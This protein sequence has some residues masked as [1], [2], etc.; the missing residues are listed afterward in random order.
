MEDFSTILGAILAVLSF[1]AIILPR[2]ITLLFRLHASFKIKSTDE[3]NANIVDSVDVLKFEA[4]WPDWE[5]SSLDGCGSS[6][7]RPKK[8]VIREEDTA[9]L[10]VPG[11][12]RVFSHMPLQSSLGKL[13]DPTSSD[14]SAAFDVCGVEFP[15]YGTFSCEQRTLLPYLRNEWDMVAVLATVDAAATRLRQVG[16]G[17]VVIVANS[18]SAGVILYAMCKTHMPGS[19]MSNL[20]QRLCSMVSDGRVRFV[21][22]NPAISFVRGHPIRHLADKPLTQFLCTVL[23]AFGLGALVVATDANSHWYYYVDGE[24]EK[25][26]K[27]CFKAPSRILVGR[28]NVQEVDNHSRLS[29]I[30]MLLRLSWFFASANVEIPSDCRASVIVAVTEQQKDEPHI[31]VERVREICRSL[32]IAIVEAN[33]HEPENHNDLDAYAAYLRKVLL[34]NASQ[35]DGSKPL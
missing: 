20:T 25:G 29:Y 7:I 13:L 28:P 2:I 24:P 14:S 15:W 3:S 18:S 8:A 22:S 30:M 1:A 4:E 35:D 31:D 23:S 27:A 21:F 19:V 33:A 5:V 11:K 34:P 10:F 6:L 12:G 9:L 16:Y 26:V 17:S 32:G